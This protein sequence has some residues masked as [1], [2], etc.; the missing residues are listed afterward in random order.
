MT[1]DL[2]I[3]N[4]LV[5]DDD[6]VVLEMVSRMIELLG[7]NSTTAEDAVDALYY[8]T[9]AHYD[10]VLVDY[11]MPSM[12]GIQLADKIKRNHFDTR[13]AVM[14]AHRRK[15]L[16]DSLETADVIDGLLIKPFNLDMLGEF[17][18]KEITGLICLT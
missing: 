2:I 4:I 11:D 9:K 14:T 13:V 6:A 5:V 1:Q 12:N 16:I 15:D 7:Y 8:L 3:N 10:L 17:I 18:E